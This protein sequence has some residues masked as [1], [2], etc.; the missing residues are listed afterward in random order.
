MSKWTCKHCD[1]VY[2]YCKENVT[3]EHLPESCAKQLVDEIFNTM[4]DVFKE[5][6]E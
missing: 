2:T 6:E 3:T 1:K 5:N 4:P